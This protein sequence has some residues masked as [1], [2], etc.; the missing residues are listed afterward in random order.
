[1]IVA[2]EE[3]KLTLQHKDLHQSIIFDFRRLQRRMEQAQTKGAPA[4]R[5][6]GEDELAP[7]GNLRYPGLASN[8]QLYSYPKVKGDFERK[9]KVFSLT[10][11]YKRLEAWRLV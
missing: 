6:G 7:D 11:E 5:L 10:R 1:M 3:Q 8:L 9:A 4:L 2:D